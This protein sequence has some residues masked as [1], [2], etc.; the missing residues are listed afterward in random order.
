MAIVQHKYI[1]PHTNEQ[2]TD[3]NE[4]LRSTNKINFFF[5]SENTILKNLALFFYTCIS[6]FGGLMTNLTLAVVL[7]N[8]HLHLNVRID[9]SCGKW[10][11]VF[12]CA[13]KLTLPILI[14][15]FFP[16]NI[17]SSEIPIDDQLSQMMK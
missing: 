7:T 13:C 9:T 16:S 3:I 8:F 5:T 12:C 10:V 14:T 11:F 1:F 15:C 2:T 6:L 4:A 17:S